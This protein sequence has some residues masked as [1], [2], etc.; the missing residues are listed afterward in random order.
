MGTNKNLINEPPLLILP[1]L[2]VAIGLNEAVFLQQLHFLMGLS[3]NEREGRKWVYNTYGQWRQIFPFWSLDTVRRTINGLE[4]AGLVVSGK[5]NEWVI[6]QTKW[7]TIDYERLAEACAK[8][9][10]I[11]A[12]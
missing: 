7:Y 12:D 8:T 9:E 1:S 3:K 5:F 4:R 10:A 11:R 2:A 6:D